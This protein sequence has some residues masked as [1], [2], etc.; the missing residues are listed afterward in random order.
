MRLYPTLI[1]LILSILC[2]LMAFTDIVPMW[3]ATLS[4]LSFVYALILLLG[5]NTFHIT[6]GY[7]LRSLPMCFLWYIP[8]AWLM[9]KL[10]LF[11]S[12]WWNL[13]VGLCALIYVIG[14][15]LILARIVFL[16]LFLGRLNSRR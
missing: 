9:D 1:F 15:G 2:G 12:I 7:W 14:V 8:C 5:K 4:G 16:Y 13:V 6:K 3:F 10:T 11:N